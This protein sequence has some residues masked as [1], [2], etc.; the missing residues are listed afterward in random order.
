MAS[1]AEGAITER[2]DGQ[3][4]EYGGY[5]EF[6]REQMETFSDWAVRSGKR[7]VSSLL[8]H[9]YRRLARY[10]VPQVGCQFRSRARPR[11]WAGRSQGADVVEFRGYGVEYDEEKGGKAHGKLYLRGSVPTANEAFFP[12]FFELVANP[13]I[14][15]VDLP[16]INRNNGEAEWS[17]VAPTRKTRHRRDKGEE[18][19]PESGR[20]VGVTYR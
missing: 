1:S 12:Q 9:Y 6:S 17:V 3:C 2:W 18:R 5:G 19:A 20:E 15:P 14:E 11:R 13:D 16:T 10:P 8:P 4:G 7:A